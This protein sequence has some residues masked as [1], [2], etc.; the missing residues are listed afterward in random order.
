MFFAL[1]TW[2]LN[3]SRLVSKQPRN[4]LETMQ[5]HPI[6]T[7]KSSMRI[8]FDDSRDSW[9]DNQSFR[10]QRSSMA[11]PWQ[12]NHC[13]FILLSSRGSRMKI[14]SCRKSFLDPSCPS[15]P[16]RTS[17]K[18]SRLSIPEKSH[19][20][21]MSFQRTIKS[22]KPWQR[23]LQVVPSSRTICWWTCL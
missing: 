6:S 22:L 14:L 7:G 17:T 9:T 1:S 3:S 5:P 8:I 16:S 11:V 2:S 10:T 15:S 21:S 19:S 4:C 20:P 13:L 23:I 12:K 18:P